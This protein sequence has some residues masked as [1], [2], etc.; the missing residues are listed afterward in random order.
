MNRPASQTVAPD[1]GLVHFAGRLPTILLLTGIFSL[2][3]LAR[4]V[5][6]PLLP[7]I[8][9]DLNIRHAAAGGLFMMISGGYFVGLLV[10][11]Q[12]SARYNHRRTI[13]LSCLA[14]AVV[15]VMAATA[16]SPNGLRAALIVLGLTCG[17]Y[18]PSGIASLTH[19]LAPT[20]FG[21]AIAFHETSPSLGFI[22]GPLLVEW[23]LCWCGWRGVL[24]PVVVGLCLAAWIY[25]RHDCR[26]DFRGEAPTLANMHRVLA[27]PVLWW[28]L[29]PFMFA[30]AANIGVYS[31]LPLFLQAGRGV[32]PAVA[33]LLLS[34]SRVAAMASP[35]LSGWATDRYGPRPVALITIVV[36]GV[37]TVMLAL[38]PDHWLW[39]PMGVQSMMATAFF[40]AGFAILITIVAPRDRNLVVS[41]VMPLSIVVGGGLL[42]TMIGL[43]ADAGRFHTGFALLGLLITTSAVFLW[44]IPARGVR[45]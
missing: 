3:F 9:K 5:W 29:V 25:G 41:L 34:A 22:V 8:E 45:R 11:G 12:L 32:D 40:P 42:P 13:V 6:G 19:R 1:D 7:T 43:F 28:M 36:G 14:S 37:A 4:F 24:W 15:L 44:R 20:D 31:M 23:L 39:L 30:V 21:K 26:E 27:R 38:V 2:N 35:L 18:L 16:T 17:L 10:S 33:N